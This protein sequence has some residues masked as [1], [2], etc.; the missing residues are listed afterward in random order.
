MPSLGQF[1]DAKR[2]IRLNP[3]KSTYR[4]I[5]P[6]I[7]SFGSVLL[8]HGN[9]LLRVLDVELVNGFGNCSVHIGCLN[10]AEP[11]GWRRTCE[12]DGPTC[13]W[14]FFWWQRSGFPWIGSPLPHLP[15]FRTPPTC[16]PSSEGVDYSR[17]GGSADALLRK[18]LRYELW[19]GASRPS[20]AVRM[21]RMSRASTSNM[22]PWR[23]KPR[24]ACG[25]R[26]T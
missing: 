9:Q 1:P 15:V 19:P 8:S 17:S 3:T 24:N 12:I 21:R 7:A 26:T 4:L 11:F 6:T 13:R 2:S 22:R 25:G 10:R 5:R 14:L 16:T 20:I 23:P 18:V